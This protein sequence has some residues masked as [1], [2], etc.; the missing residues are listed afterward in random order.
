MSEFVVRVETELEPQVAWARLWD[1]ERHTAV[2][3]L[4]T[5]ALDPPALAL[6]EGVG[7]TG[8]TA[9]GPLGFDDT[10]RVLVWEPPSAS[11]G[12]AVVTK[13]GALIAGRIE[14]TFAPSRGGKTQI[15]WRQ[16]VALPWLPSRLSWA[17]GLAA[18]AAAPGYRRVLRTLLD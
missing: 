9:L 8:R 12:R 15:T 10:M 4:T 2:I 13:T 14:A 7:F 1:L 3:P 11:G 5:V 6:G 16:D 18:R 17:E